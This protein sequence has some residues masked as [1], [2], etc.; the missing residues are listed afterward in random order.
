MD[1]QQD[2]VL[3]SFVVLVRYRARVVAVR[4]SRIFYFGSTLARR[5]ADA[6]RATQSRL[7]LKEILLLLLQNYFLIPKRMFAS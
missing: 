4:R 7:A 6:L 5:D 2:E 3:V 1:A